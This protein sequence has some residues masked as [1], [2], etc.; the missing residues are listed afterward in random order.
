[1]S[2]HL[3]LQCSV[4]TQHKLFPPSIPCSR[5]KF[6]PSIPTFSIQHP[7]EKQS[8][9]ISLSW[10]CHDFI[11]HILQYTYNSSRYTRLQ[12]Q[13]ASLRQLTGMPRIVTFRAPPW[14]KYSTHGRIIFIIGIS[15]YGKMILIWKCNPLRLEFWGSF[16]TAKILAMAGWPCLVSVDNETLPS[17]YVVCI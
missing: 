8:S 17:T 16:S 4:S 14:W 13:K 3:M 12:Q 11:A 15:I 9:D 6:P 1:M 2:S 7:D 5:A 10:A